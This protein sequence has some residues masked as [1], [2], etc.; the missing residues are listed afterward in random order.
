MLDLRKFSILVVGGGNVAFRKAKSILESGAKFSAIALNFT[1]EFLG[2]MND[3]N[4]DY[5]VKPYEQGDIGNHKLIFCCTSDK[6]VNEIVYKDAI[7]K[8]ALINVV[9][10]PELCNFIMPAVIKRGN[11]IISIS[12][13]GLAPFYAKKQKEELDEL[14]SPLLEDV[15]ELAGLFRLKVL[16]LENL[17]MRSKEALFQAFL[18][19]NWQKIIYEFD[20]DYAKGQMDNIIIKF[21]NKI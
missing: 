9:D 21:L 5:Q 4:L 20:F 19:I 13:Q 3:N 10:V 6:K 17:S 11:M 14:L 18:E 15:T 12:T 8:S 1:H 7:E 2:L 16:Q